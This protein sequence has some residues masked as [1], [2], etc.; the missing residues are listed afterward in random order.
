MT[1]ERSGT[2]LDRA[3]PFDEASVAGKGLLNSTVRDHLRGRS[4]VRRTGEFN[5]AG[6]AAVGHHLGTDA[7]T[8]QSRPQANAD[9]RGSAASVT[10]F[11]PRPVRFK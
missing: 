10:I 11:G 1:H 3:L 5:A 9:L 6:I 4:G 7:G 2:A 8:C